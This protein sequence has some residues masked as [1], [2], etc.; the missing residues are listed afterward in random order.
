M[1][2]AERLKK[3]REKA[4]YSQ[5]EVAEKLNISRQAISKWENGWTYPDMDNLVLL[6]D[7]YGVS[8]DEILKGNSQE[9]KKGKDEKENIILITKENRD[10]FMLMVITVIGCMI[11]FIGTIAILAVFIYV[12]I[13]KAKLPII[14]KVIM[15]LCLIISLQNIWAFM[16]TM[17]FHVGKSTI[18]KVALL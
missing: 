10:N 14:Y 3:A 7:L 8:T 13:K 16:N 9:T 4:G 12:A 2:L 11:P 1:L 5:N 18:E 17:W 6:S 15:G